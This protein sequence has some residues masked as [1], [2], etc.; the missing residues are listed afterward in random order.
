MVDIKKNLKLLWTIFYTFL[1]ISPLTFG[2]GYAMLAIIET[3]VVKKRKWIKKEDI[4]DIF[5][6]AQS[7]PGAV[8]INSAI[9]VG[10]RIFGFIG[11]V[12][13]L[14]GILIPTLIIVIIISFSYYFFHKNPIVEA[15]FNGIGAAVIALIVYAGVSIGKSAVIDVTTLVFTIISFAILCFLHINPIFVIMGGFIGGIAVSKLK[16]HRKERIKMNSENKAYYN[17]HF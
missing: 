1:K 16:A 11:A 3:E 6:V 4:V 8:A 2:G 5:T 12:V 15:A 14:L 9:F 13:G 7:V 17:D 10:Y